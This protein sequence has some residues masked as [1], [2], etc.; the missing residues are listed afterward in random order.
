MPDSLCSG[1]LS[2]IESSEAR[3]ELLYRIC[4]EP[5]Q[6]LCAMN[7]PLTLEGPLEFQANWA[8]WCLYY[9]TY[10]H[11]S[12]EVDDGEQLHELCLPRSASCD[13]RPTRTM[14]MLPVQPRPRQHSAPAPTCSASPQ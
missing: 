1:C 10:A 6:S 8:Y 12:I 4:R 3:T 2:P 14:P 5:L 11:T 7:N 9:G 13:L